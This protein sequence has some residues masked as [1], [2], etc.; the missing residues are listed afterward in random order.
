MRQVAAELV[1]DLG[2]PFDA[3]WRRLC[4]V[5]GPREG[6][7]V[8]AKVLG[9]VEERGLLQVAGQLQQALE[10]DEPLL[11]ALAAPES[12]ALVAMEK[13]PKSVQLIDIASGCAADY[14]AWLVG[15]AQ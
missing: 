7:R 3:A 14:D 5:H 6:A 2:A 10:R 11:L 4:D 12:P 1:R 15:G 13:L 9:H 8:F